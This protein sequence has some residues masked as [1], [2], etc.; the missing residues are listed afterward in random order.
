MAASCDGTVPHQLGI[1]GSINRSK[2]PSQLA[3][4]INNPKP[5][6]EQLQ[7]K[8]S[9]PGSKSYHV[10]RWLETGSSYSRKN[11]I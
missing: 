4:S 3:S 8:K 9:K 11:G 10:L 2:Y 5:K 1:K 7:K 6:S